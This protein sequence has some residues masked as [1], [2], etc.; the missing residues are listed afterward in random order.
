VKNAVRQYF[1]NAF[2]G[3][4]ILRE[5]TDEVLVLNEKD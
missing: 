1:N 5:F 3:K 4:I 2:S